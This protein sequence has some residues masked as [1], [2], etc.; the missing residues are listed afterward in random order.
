MMRELL[1]N[2]AKKILERSI[3]WLKEGFHLFDT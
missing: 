2:F 3:T 1:F